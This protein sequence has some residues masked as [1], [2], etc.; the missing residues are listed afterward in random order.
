MS[1]PLF[2]STATVTI[3]SVDY[4]DLISNVVFTP[5]TPSVEFKGVS[6]KVATST[7]ATT[8]AV[9]FDYA[10]SFDTAGSLALK[11][12]NDSGDKVTA[13]F[14]PQGSASAASVTAT[15]TLLSGSF[16]GAIDAAAT[17]SVTLPVDGKPT[18]TPAAA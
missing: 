9:T 13:V 12:F 5:T 6:G 11:L 1:N 8:W 2:I 15:V 3:D 7:G 16:G 14:K 4:A 18:I 10:Q 17:S